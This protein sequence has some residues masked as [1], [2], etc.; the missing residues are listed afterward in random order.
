MLTICVH[1]IQEYISEL[2]NDAALKDLDLVYFEIWRLVVKDNVSILLHQ[3]FCVLNH[4]RLAFVHISYYFAC[5]SEKLH[6]CREVGTWNGEVPYAQT[7]NGGSTDRGSCLC[8]TETHGKLFPLLIW[9]CFAIYS[10]FLRVYLWCQTCNILPMSNS[11]WLLSR[12]M[13]LFWRVT[14][15]RM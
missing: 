3:T 14:L 2:R 7:Y 10:Y 11:L 12:F 8:D 4:Y 15:L 13:G 5:I 1:L 6:G 9:S